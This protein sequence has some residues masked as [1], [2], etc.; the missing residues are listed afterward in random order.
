MEHNNEIRIDSPFDKE[1]IKELRAGDRVLLTGT[2]YT[3]RD[4]AHKRLTEAL[5][6]GKTLPFELENAAVYY[7][8]PS[9]APEGRC[10]GSAGPTTSY[11]MDPYAPVMMDHGQT[12]MIG[13]GPR[14]D[15]VKAAMKRNGAVYLAA[16]GGCGALMSKC[17]VASELIAYEDLGA[18]AV[19]KLTVKNMPLIVVTDRFGNDLY[20]K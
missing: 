9:P 1:K 3:A 11:R 19:R 2:V 6:A 12:I 20:E 10:I 8:G 15:E 18:E 16:I 5:A 13:K 4:Q 14:N 7:V 17:I